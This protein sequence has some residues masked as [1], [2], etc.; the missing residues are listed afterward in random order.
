LLRKHIL[1]SDDFISFC[2][3]YYLDIDLEVFFEATEDWNSAMTLSNSMAFISQ[4]G[5]V[6]LQKRMSQI[7]PIVIHRLST[8]AHFEFC[9]NAA[10]THSQT[11]VQS[12]RW[13]RGS[14]EVPE[15]VEKA[16]SCSAKR[17]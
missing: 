9:F 6:R 8:V 12:W 3:F 5:E 1:F 2:A 13:S 15:R 11:L 7:Q 16:G 10:P 4:F 14:I 17:T